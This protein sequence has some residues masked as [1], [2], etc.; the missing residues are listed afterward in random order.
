V[1]LAGEGVWGWAR[2][3]FEAGSA[4][5]V[6]VAMLL[7]RLVC[8]PAVRR[9]QP[10]PLW[11]RV[12]YPVNALLL[13]GALIL[14][15]MHLSSCCAACSCAAPWQCTATL[16]SYWRTYPSPATLLLLAPSS[17]VPTACGA[18]WSCWHP[19]T[20]CPPSTCSTAA[21]AVTGTYRPT[22]W[23]VQQQQQQVLAGPVGCRPLVPR[24]CQAQGVW[25]Q[26]LV[27]WM[28]QLLLLLAWG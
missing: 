28:L 18:V 6:F 17:S 8:E 3:G 9:V 20:R 15:S 16:L 14:H 1:N 27:R 19:Q 7:S 10:Q 5:W 11:V 23:H 21:A 24:C 26:Q 2:E 22:A 25:G 13:A 12:L 4:P